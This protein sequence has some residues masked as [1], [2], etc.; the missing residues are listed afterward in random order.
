MSA[1]ATMVKYLG[2]SSIDMSNGKIAHIFQIFH[3]KEFAD[4]FSE[5]SKATCKDSFGVT[6]FENGIVT[7]VSQVNFSLATLIE[8]LHNSLRPDSNFNEELSKVFGKNEEIKS[9]SFKFNEIPLEVT[10]N[11]YEEELF[12]RYINTKNRQI[13]Q[14]SS[15][16]GRIVDQKL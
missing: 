8:V 14:K 9:F 6:N 5:L 7:V 1:S 13:S 4:K 16:Q 11:T 15:S 12:H 10:K 3:N 2:V